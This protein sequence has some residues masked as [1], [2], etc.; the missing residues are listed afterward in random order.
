MVRGER[1]RRGVRQVKRCAAG[2]PDRSGRYGEDESRGALGLARGMRN[3]VCYEKPGVRP[4]KK[5]A[6][7]A[8]DSENGQRLTVH[9]T[10]L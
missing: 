1:E 10:L 8:Q 5:P 6:G 7:K 2:G 3:R 4:A 9:R